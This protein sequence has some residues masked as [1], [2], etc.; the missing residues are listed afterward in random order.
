M[1]PRPRSW[2]RENCLT[3]ITENRINKRKN[4]R[5]PTEV[6][7]PVFHHGRRLCCAH[8]PILQ[9][10]ISTR[11]VGNDWKT[12]CWRVIN[13]YYWASERLKYDKHLHDGAAEASTR[14]R[15]C[16]PERETS[17]CIFSYKG[18]WR[19]WRQTWLSTYVFILCG[20]FLLLL[21]SLQCERPLMISTICCGLIY[22]GT[23]RERVSHA[24]ISGYS[25]WWLSVYGI[26]CWFNESE[27]NHS[28][29]HRAGRSYNVSVM[30]YES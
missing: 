27:T 20:K 8:F 29:G 10:T 6:W 22:W 19:Q 30:V 5:A 9:S 1:L 28:F 11:K 3:Q 15:N 14:V 21:L 4:I 12:D 17:E 7:L 24:R 13:L 25:S 26:V 16:P 2:S 18:I 23:S